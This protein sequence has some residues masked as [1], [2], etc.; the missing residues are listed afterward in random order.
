MKIFYKWICGYLLLFSFV[1]FFSL[2][3]GGDDSSDDSSSGKKP[4]NPSVAD[5]LSKALEGSTPS[6]Q[7]ELI[8][9]QKLYGTECSTKKQKKTSVCKN[10]E[11]AIKSFKVKILHEQSEPQ[12]EQAKEQRERCDTAREQFEEKSKS[13]QER[14]TSLM[15]DHYSLEKQVSELEETM[16]KNQR[17]LAEE[18][19][20]LQDKTNQRVQTL[21]DKLEDKKIEIDNQIQQLQTKI[22]E[23]STQLNQL[24]IKKDEAYLVRRQAIN[25][26][27]AGCFAEAKAKTK[28]IQTKFNIRKQKKCFTKNQYGDFG[29]GYLTKHKNRLSNAF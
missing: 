13:K 15:E 24:K 18:L 26:I 10:L 9:Y 1:S 2:A 12:R 22:F 27:Y 28:E 23:I 19:N 16:Q 3:P 14:E 6:A 11:T 29:G 25:N 20:T 8:K 4:K 21:K 7:A 17:K 5:A